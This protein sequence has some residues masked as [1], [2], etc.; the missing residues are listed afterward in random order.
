MFLRKIDLV[1]GGPQVSIFNEGS[2]KTIF[3]GALSLIYLILFLLIAIAYLVDYVSNDKYDVQYSIHQEVLSDDKINKLMENSDYN[4]N[5][6]FHILLSDSSKHL[7]DRFVI[8]DQ[9]KDEFY[10]YQAEIK[11]KLNET[12]FGVFYKCENQTCLLNEED[13]TEFGY[14]L[15]IYYQGYLLDHQGEIPLHQNDQFYGIS[16]IFFFNKPLFQYLEWGI[17]KYSE[18]RAFLGVFYNLFGEEDEELVGGYFRGKSYFFLDGILPE[19]K[20]IEQQNGTYYKLL[21]MYS[22]SVDLFQFELYKRTKKIILDVFAD[23]SALSMTVLEI[24]AFILSNYYSGNFDNYKIIEKVLSKEKIQIFRN[25][26]I[27]EDKEDNKKMQ[28]ELTDNIEKSDALLEGNSELEAKDN[29]IEDKDD[30]AGNKYEEELFLPKLRFIDFIMNS[31]Y[32][33]KCCKISNRQQLISSCND[34]VSKYFTIEYIIYNQIK[35]ENL[36]KDYKWNDPKLGNINNN[37]FFIELKSY[38][39]I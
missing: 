19:E 7:S 9:N 38:Y 2:N 12:S 3:G 10:P 18:E 34:L 35:I 23:I 30:N 20:M 8:Y 31:F 6:T 1:S 33:E 16:S 36:L 32:S 11:S 26:D 15:D 25:K 21:S 17:I 39:N 24:F 29:L 28:I 14:S 4:P 22:I 5:L 13:I 37:K 27:S